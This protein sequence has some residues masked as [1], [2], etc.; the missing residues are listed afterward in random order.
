MEN[1]ENTEI[2]TENETSEQITQEE[3]LEEVT[4]EEVITEEVTTEEVTTEEIEPIDYTE[5]LEDISEQL[6]RLRDSI[7]NMSSN[8][9]NDGELVIPDN[10]LII[11]GSGTGDFNL[12]LSGEVENAS[13]ND[14]FSVGISIRNVLLVFLLAWLCLKLING[15][16]GVLYRLMNR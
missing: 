2:V 8:N 12:Y 10:D 13:L 14:I 15:F 1:N 6:E 4:T 11:L 5:Y 7:S 9:R 3:N 16:K